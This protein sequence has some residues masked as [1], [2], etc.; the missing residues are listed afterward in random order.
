MFFG[1]DRDQ[2]RRFF[3]ESWRKRQAGAPLEPLEHLVADI[4]G[5]HPEYHAALGAG[6]D[7]L[8]QRD[9]T[10]EGGESNPFLHMGLHIAIAEQVGADRPPGVRAVY[11][12]LCRRLGDAHQVEHM[13]LELLGETLWQAQR[14]G[15]PPDEAAYL[16]RLRQIERD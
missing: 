3:L 8:L 15:H 10:P 7:E 1:Q 2:M 14:S 5:R 6:G 13:M 9:Y 11:E 12:S 4:V 16:E